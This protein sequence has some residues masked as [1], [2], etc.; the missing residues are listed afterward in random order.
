MR[1]KTV[2]ISKLI[3]KESPVQTDATLLANSTTPDIVGCYMLRDVLLHTL[4]H[5][6]VCCSKFETGQSFEPTTPNISF[7]PL[8]PKRNAT[9]GPFIR[10]KIT[11]VLHKTRTVPFIRA[12]LI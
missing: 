12:C 11:R 5:V 4:F 8:S 3:P 9:I 7:V 6:V 10:R 2:H 1:L